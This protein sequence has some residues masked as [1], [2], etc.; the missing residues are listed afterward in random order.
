MWPR[1]R[2]GARTLMAYLIGI[3]AA[4]WLVQRLPL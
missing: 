3:P 2:A 4:F 1:W